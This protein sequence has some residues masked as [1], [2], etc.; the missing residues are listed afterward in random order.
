MLLTVIKQVCFLLSC[1]YIHNGL[2][3]LREA[4]DND[5]DDLFDEIQKAY[6][7]DDE[8]A[9]TARKRI[10]PPLADNDLPNSRSNATNAITTPAAVVSP[11]DA[12]AIVV[13][14]I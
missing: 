14:R 4:Y 6:E 13:V 7:K 10:M 2:K 5:N 8:K 3:Q 11:N 1:L 12:D 9:A